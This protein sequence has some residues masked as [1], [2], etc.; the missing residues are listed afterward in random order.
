MRSWGGGRNLSGTSLNNMKEEEPRYFLHKWLKTDAVLPAAFKFVPQSC[1]GVWTDGNYLGIIKQNA[2]WKMIHSSCAGVLYFTEYS[3]PINQ[4]SALFR[5]VNVLTHVPKLVIWKL[6]NVQTC[7][8]SILEH[9]NSSKA[10]Q[11]RILW[12]V[13]CID[14]SSH[15]M[16]FS[17]TRVPRV[18]RSPRVWWLVSRSTRCSSSSSSSSPS[19]EPLFKPLCVGASAF[20]RSSLAGRPSGVTRTLPAAEGIAAGHKD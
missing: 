6:K 18:S 3:G 4:P 15:K 9:N 13:C 16:F 19:T 11:T 8:S 12:W 2:P 7:C 1:A 10:G 17:S 14:F 20:T 5:G